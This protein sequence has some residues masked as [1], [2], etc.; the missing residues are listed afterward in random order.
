MSFAIIPQNLSIV[1]MRSS[2]YRDSAHALAELIDN[3]IQAGESLN[4]RI[5]VE[6]I[7]VDGVDHSSGSKRRKL[8]RIGVFDNAAGMDPETL[9]KALQFG[10]GS[11]LS[12]SSQKGIGKFGMGLPNSSI[13]QCRRVDVWTWQ[14]G[15]VFHTFLALDAIENET[16]NEVP[17]PEISTLPQEWIKLFKADVGE[18]G[19]LVVWTEL[20]RVTW[21][22]SAALLRHAEFIIGRIYRYFINDGRAEIRLASYEES[23]GLFN[24]TM[25]QNV[26][27]NDPLYLMTGTSS[28][29]P[30]DQNPAFQSLGQPQEIEIGFNGAKHLVTIT[31]SI[32]K[33]ETR[34]AGGRAKIGQDTR[35][36]LGVSVVRAGRELE[37]NRSFDVSSEPRERWWGVEVSF[38]PGLDPIFGVTNNKQTATEFKQ[39]DIEEDAIAQDI[40]LAEYKEMLSQDNDPRQAMYTIS[41][42]ITSL[43]H[44]AR[45]QIA[46]M[47]EGAR[48]D[49]TGAP[50]GPTAEVIATNALRRRQE[51][52]GRTGTS[53]EAETGSA[54][55]RAEALSGEIVQEGIGSE[56]AKEIAVD[57]VSRKIKFLFRHA[58]FPGFAVF[59]VTSKAGVIIITINTKHPA[60]E[61][62]FELL[63]EDSEPETPALQGLKLL[64]TAWARMEDEASSE[65]KIEFEDTRGEWGKIARDFMREACD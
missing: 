29:E 15:K 28:P 50:D 3:S 9:R 38:E 20:D 47:R 8:S 61:H 60:H 16:M 63:W 18:S 58:D 42:A 30:F 26:R 17:E 13:S 55:E 40:S 46:R 34:L 35:N 14:N 25:D 21:K 56:R 7:C 51:K 12:A 4:R 24:N 37:L 43:L 27:P 10:N 64:L 6:V 59:D 1:A 48:T 19:T 36:N 53:D 52:L 54:V 5:N 57:Y 2:G 22:R 32:C 23:A 33:P 49:S 41:N 39:L 65:K 31:A 62:L 44:T 45:A 11:H